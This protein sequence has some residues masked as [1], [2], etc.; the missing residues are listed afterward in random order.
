[1]FEVR[2][3]ER[4]EGQ[5]VAAEPT[6]DL[7]FSFGKEMKLIEIQFRFLACKVYLFI[8]V[9][10]LIWPFSIRIGFVPG[11]VSGRAEPTNDLHFS[12]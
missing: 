3:E 2:S 10:R 11:R 12:F 7:H 4:E 5:G 8:F 1:M 6:N 9:L